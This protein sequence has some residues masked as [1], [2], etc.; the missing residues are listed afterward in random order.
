MLPLC[1]GGICQGTDIID[2]RLRENCGVFLAQSSYTCGAPAHNHPEIKIPL[3]LCEVTDSRTRSPT[4]APRKIPNLPIGS[5]EN[6]LQALDHR[7]GARTQFSK[8]IQF[9]AHGRRPRFSQHLAGNIASVSHLIEQSSK[10]RCLGVRDGASSDMHHIT[11]SKTRGILVLVH[12]FFRPSDRFG[13][14]YDEDQ[15]SVCAVANRPRLLCVPDRGSL[16]E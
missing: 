8:P 11:G 12:C 14:A 7:I 9:R 6:R 2:T 13:R 10:F 15:V 5:V 16:G 1:A 3:Y 4:S